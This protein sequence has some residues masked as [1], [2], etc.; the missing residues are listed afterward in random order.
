[1]YLEKVCPHVFFFGKKL[2]IDR[3]LLPDIST[4]A[5]GIFAKAHVELDKLQLQVR[6]EVFRELSPLQRQELNTV[7]GKPFLFRDQALD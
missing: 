6:E 4:K 2:H 5:G 7:L 1:M 3:R